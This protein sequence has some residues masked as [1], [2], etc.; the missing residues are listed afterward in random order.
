MAMSSILKFGTCYEFYWAKSFLITRSDFRI[1][2]TFRKA[3][4][5]CFFNII[6]FL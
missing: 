4:N 3:V 5:Q 1:E 2:F 6:V